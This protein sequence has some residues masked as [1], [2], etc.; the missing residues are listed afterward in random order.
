MNRGWDEKQLERES[1]SVCVRERK[2]VNGEEE[3]IIYQI[4]RT[5]EEEILFF[6]FFRTRTLVSLHRMAAH[7]F[8][9]AF[10]VATS[11]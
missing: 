3:K 2:R 7:W 1:V 10:R 6:F 5:G 9:C 8:L 11:K 4:N